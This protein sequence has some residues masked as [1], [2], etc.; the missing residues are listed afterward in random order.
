MNTIVDILVRLVHFH[1]QVGEVKHAAVKCR[2]KVNFSFVLDSRVQ[3]DASQCSMSNCS[4]LQCSILQY[5]TV[6][7]HTVQ[8]NTVQ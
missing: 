1:I 2:Y 3:F 6:Q 5:D 7:Y 8:Y 4:D